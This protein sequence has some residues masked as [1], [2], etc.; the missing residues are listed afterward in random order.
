ML[1]K[2][3]IQFDK[4]HFDSGQHELAVN[5]KSTFKRQIIQPDIFSHLYKHF[6]FLKGL[7]IQ[8]YFKK[9]V[10]FWLNHIIRKAPNK[11]NSFSNAYYLTLKCSNSRQK[12]LHTTIFIFS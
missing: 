11:F 8:K 4:I 7:I 6:H 9:G 2:L 3:E 1:F 5:Y 12:P 10:V